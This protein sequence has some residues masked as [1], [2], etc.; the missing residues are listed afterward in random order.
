MITK[1]WKLYD[2]STGYIYKISWIVHSSETK[3][4]IVKKS[5]IVSKFQDNTH[6]IRDH[7]NSLRLT[8]NTRKPEERENKVHIDLS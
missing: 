6:I 1:V 5:K 2:S 8:E 7:S 4:P 3:Y